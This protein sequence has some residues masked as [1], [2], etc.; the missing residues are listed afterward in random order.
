MESEF[1][2]LFHQLDTLLLQSR[3]LWQVAPFEAKGL[4]WEDDFPALSQVVWAI[5]DAQ[6][7]DI[8]RDAEQLIKK[9][10]PALKQDVSQQELTQRSASGTPADKLDWRW[11]LFQGTW[12]QV[13]GVSSIHCDQ[14]IAHPDVSHSTASHFT[15]QQLSRLSAG[16]KGRKWQQICAFSDAISQFSDGYQ[17]RQNSQQNDDIQCENVSNLCQN[18]PLQNKFPQ[19]KSLH[20]QSYDSRPVLEWCAG[21]GHLGRLLASRF[22]VPVVSLE[23]QAQLCD[24]GEQLALQKQLPQTF[25]C[26]DAF[27]LQPSPFKCR[28]HAVALHACGDLH[29]TLLKQASQ[30]Q[31]QAVSLSPC[32][33]HLIQHKTYQPISEVAQAS[34]MRLSRRDL[35]LPLQQSV[36]ANPKQQALRLQEVAWRLAFDSLQRQTR[37]VDE[38]LPI[39]TVKQSQLSGNFVEFCRW[40]AAQKN[41]ELNPAIDFDAFLLL[42]I[43]RQRLT[44]RIDLVA[45][46]FRPI[47]ELW[48]LLD[49]CCFLEEQGY[50]VSLQAFCDV[51][52]TPRNA[53]IHATWHKSEQSFAV[54][55]G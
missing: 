22:Q 46:L 33:Y 44:R 34:A 26:A 12:D 37:G 41:L 28:Q 38:Y 48:L 2:R 35:Q 51:Q 25:I 54:N 7:D 45:H 13:A 27:Q 39:P 47:I 32:C 49:R 42:G 50:C 20:N 43:Q 10:L 53:L 17:N 24:A 8:D 14:S 23:W 6:I 36:I 21:K 29:V 1:S 31:T 55:D 11:H 4:P 3:C 18:K 15:S 16:I 30:A 40:A 52:L 5:E 9:L 19:N